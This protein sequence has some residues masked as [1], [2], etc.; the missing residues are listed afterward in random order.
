[1][2]LLTPYK[3]VNTK[4]IGLY[5]IIFDSL[6]RSKILSSVLFTLGDMYRYIKILQYSKISQYNAAR[7]VH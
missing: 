3:G 7:L 6:Y 5:A 4:A 1:M 2:Q